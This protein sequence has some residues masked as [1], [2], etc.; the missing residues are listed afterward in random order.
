MKT[1][2]APGVL[3]L[4]LGVGAL[5]AQDATPPRSRTP[6]RPFT[7]EDLER[8]KREREA[9]AGR[10]PAPR[11]TPSEP[12]SAGPA[13]PEGGES[14]A[15]EGSS[16]DELRKA[17]AAAEAARD[18][19]RAR[20]QRLEASLNP[21]SPGFETDPNVILALQAELPEARAALEER[22]TAVAG[23]RAQLEAA[24]AQA[25]RPGDPPPSRER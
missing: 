7:N 6:P 20:V 21:M 1:R 13:T 2:L 16:P 8:Y 24:E 23:A 5:A 25:R 10:T 11:A 3:G 15:E 18:E 12:A 14:A 4:A 9:E 19:A 17:L 22:E